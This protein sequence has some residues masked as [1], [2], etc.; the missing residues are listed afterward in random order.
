[1]SSVSLVNVCVCVCE[2]AFGSRNQV[3]CNSF[4]MIH[5]IQQECLCAC[6][7]F[8]CSESCPAFP[9]DPLGDVLRALALFLLQRNTSLGR[10]F[11]VVFLLLF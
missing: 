4:C 5:T 11:V 6:V 3:V 8:I 2:D 10:C 1:M 7:H 9:L